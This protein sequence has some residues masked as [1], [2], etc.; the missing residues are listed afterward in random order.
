M[1]REVRRALPAEDIVYIADSAYCPYGDRPAAEVRRRALAIGRHLEAEAKLIVVACNTATGAALDELR[2]VVKVPAVGLEPAVKTAAARTRTGR[3]GVM[4]TS[5]TLASERFARLVRQYASALQLVARPCPGL[6]EL[7]EEG[8]LRGPRMEALLERL[9]QPLRAAGVDAVVLGCT[10]YP[11]VRETLAAVL[12]PDVELIDSGPA[13]ARRTLAL[14]DE[15]R[16]RRTDG[17]GTL[18]VFTTGDPEA[19]AAVVEHVWGT[20]LPVAHVDVPS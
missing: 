2:Q 12:G 3:I 15:G 10:H 19:V 17:P 9:C 18:H 4:A 1:A 13:I 20:P 14:L 5:G 6:V 11:F 7:I 8:A 16:L